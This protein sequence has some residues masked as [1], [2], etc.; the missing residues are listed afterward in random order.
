MGKAVCTLY[1]AR[2]ADVATSIM[3]L[4]GLTMPGS[5]EAFFEGVVGE[6]YLWS[7]SFTLQGGS[8]EVLK[9]IVAQRGLKLS[10]R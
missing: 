10:V 5:E 8:V 7:P 9:N 4:H 3:G 6:S 2:L 1:E